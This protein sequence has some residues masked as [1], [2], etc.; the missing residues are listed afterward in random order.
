MRLA[1]YSSTH[2]IRTS[3][4]DI[5]II[6]SNYVTGDRRS[7]PA[8]SNGTDNQRD[9][10]GVPLRYD[11]LRLAQQRGGRSSYDEGRPKLPSMVADNITLPADRYLTIWTSVEC[12]SG[13]LSG[14]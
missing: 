3:L 1:I 6:A 12:V 13:D 2:E 8:T 9:S 5:F 7:H 4:S 11:M 10:I 14:V